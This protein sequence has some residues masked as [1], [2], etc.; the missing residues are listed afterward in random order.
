MGSTRHGAVCHI[1][2]ASLARWRRP[3]AVDAC[4]TPRIKNGSPRFAAGITPSANAPGF[5][6]GQQRRLA[7]STHAPST[8]RSI[9]VVASMS[10]TQARRTFLSDRAFLRLHAQSRF[11]RAPARSSKG[12]RQHLKPVRPCEG[13]RRS[14]KPSSAHIPNLR[15]FSPDSCG[16]RWFRRQ[17]RSLATLQLTKPRFAWA[18]A[19]IAEI[20]TSMHRVGWFRCLRGYNSPRCQSVAIHSRAEQGPAERVNIPGERES[21]D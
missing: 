18:T 14:K 21:V 9:A 8:G 2:G 3:D 12:R 4:S 7:G 6:I 11:T 16:F 1:V 17:R 10:T 19:L 5:C 15:S 13:A 20:P